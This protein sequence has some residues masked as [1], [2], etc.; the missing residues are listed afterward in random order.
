MN[1]KQHR[2]ARTKQPPISL[3]TMQ[4]RHTDLEK[5]SEIKIN[6]DGARNNVEVAVQFVSGVQ[7]DPRRSAHV[8][9]SAYG[10]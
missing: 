9:A 6:Q 3:G 8:G 2:I 5:L 10:G 4:G 1:R 7:A